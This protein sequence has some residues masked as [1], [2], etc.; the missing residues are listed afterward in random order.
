MII[1]LESGEPAEPE[2]CHFIKYEFLR[3]QCE[4]IR[5]SDS[6]LTKSLRKS[7]AV[8]MSYCVPCSRGKGTHMSGTMLTV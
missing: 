6:E 5:E 1:L 2:L 7:P 8:V 4:L 3:K